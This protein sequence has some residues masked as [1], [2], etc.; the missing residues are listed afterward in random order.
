MT[1]TSELQDLLASLERARRATAPELDAAFL[2]EVAKIEHAESEDEQTA[3]ARI[4]DAFNQLM[5]RNPPRD[6]DA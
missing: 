5:L 3:L 4:E 6:H 1:M 2:E